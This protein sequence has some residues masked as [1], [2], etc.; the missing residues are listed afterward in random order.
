MQNLIKSSVEF[1]V[2]PIL[3]DDEVVIK[4]LQKVLT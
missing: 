3:K 2:D 1:L 4:T